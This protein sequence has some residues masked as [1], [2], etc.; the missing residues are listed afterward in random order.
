[1]AEQGYITDEEK[2]KAQEEPLKIIRNAGIMD[3]PHFVLYVKQLLAEQFGEKMV[4]QSG[5]KVITTLDY[6]KQKI[7]ESA[8]K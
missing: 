8:I 2:T 4:D 1:M 5:L 6:D 3:A 7:A